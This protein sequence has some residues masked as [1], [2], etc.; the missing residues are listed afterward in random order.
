M[1]KESSREAKG[2]SAGLD[3]VGMGPLAGPICAA[4]VVFPEDYPAI[5]G[6]TDSKKL[7]FEERATLA[8]II[9]QEAVFFGVGWASAEVIDTKGKSEAWNRACLDALEGAPTVDLLK[10]DGNVSLQRFAGEQQSFVKG[11]ARFWHIGAASIVAKVVRDLEMIGMSKHHPEYRWEKNMGYGTPEH[12]EALFRLGPTHL[13]RGSFLKK[14]FHKFRDR[15]DRKQKSWE[16]WMREW[17]QTDDD[18]FNPE[19]ASY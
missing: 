8:P 4:V 9:M 18:L 5:E 14:M 17:S 12:L 16:K 7:S 2:L 11:D 6:V 15:I 3:E 10:I 1:Q 19:D 13:H